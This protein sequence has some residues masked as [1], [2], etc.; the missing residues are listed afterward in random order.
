[1]FKRILFSFHNIFA[2]F[3]IRFDCLI[4]HTTMIWNLCRIDCPRGPAKIVRSCQ[5]F[6]FTDWSMFDLAKHLISRGLANIKIK[7]AVGLWQ[8]LIRKSLEQVP[9]WW[10]WWQ[11]CSWDMDVD[12]RWA[13]S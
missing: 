10:W 11:W 12:A 8:H 6:E 7:Q 4:F 1:M 13:W 2:V 3:S 9:A 5:S